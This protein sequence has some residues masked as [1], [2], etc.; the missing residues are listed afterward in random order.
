MLQGI[1]G[2]KATYDIARVNSLGHYCTLFL[3][4]EYLGVVEVDESI[5][6]TT[7]IFQPNCVCELST[8]FPM[9]LSIKDMGPLVIIE[10]G[11]ALILCLE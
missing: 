6:H 7:C 5:H 8:F 1:N 10:L 11:L 2:M 9:G 4:E 3:M